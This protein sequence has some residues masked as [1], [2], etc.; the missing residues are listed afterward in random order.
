VLVAGCAPGVPDAPESVGPAGS[1]LPGLDS[2][3]IAAFEEGKT[4]FHKQFK[5]EEGLGPLFNQERCSSCHDLPTLGG[6]GA[7]PITKATRFDPPDRCDLLVEFG[8][9]N[10][11]EFATPL[12]IQYGIMHEQ[13]PDTANAIAAILPPP[14]YGMGLI[15]AIREADITTRADPDDRDGDGISGRIGRT[16]DGRVGRFGKKADFANLPDFIDHAIRVELGITT[17]AHPAEETINGRPIPPETDP[18]PDPEI[19][20]RQLGLLIDFVRYLAAPDRATPPSEA[21]ADT[22]R[23]GEGIFE[24]IGCARCHSPAMRTGPSP[25]TALGER[26][27]RLYSDLLLHDMGED[28][29]S[30]CGVNALPSEW[31]TAPLMGLRHRHRYLHDGR[32]GSFDQTLR[33]HGGE[34]SVARAGYGRLSEADRTAL[35]RFLSSL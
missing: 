4:L 26:T 3:R 1:L 22:V 6:E 23:A 25:V 17:P 28:L 27:V 32:A 14:L 5:P 20:A 33:L 7:E 35:F 34:A 2:A 15:E 11:Q 10:I 12:L 18:A 31:R 16:P 21:E 19:D 13:I 24:A 9:D 30:A 8:G 29:A